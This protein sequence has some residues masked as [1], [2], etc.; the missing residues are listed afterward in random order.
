MKLFPGVYKML[1]LKG[2]FFKIPIIFV[3]HS[4]DMINIS[5]SRTTKICSAE[6]FIK[7]LDSFL[8]YS[9]SKLNYITMEKIYEK[10]K[11]S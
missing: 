11:N 7:R 8:K 1:I 9:N 4:W 5:G 10:A 6:K 2:K 3:M